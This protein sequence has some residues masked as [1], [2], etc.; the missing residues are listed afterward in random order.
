MYVCFFLFISEIQSHKN[1]TE[2]VFS[3]QEV[4]IDTPYSDRSICTSIVHIHTEE[5]MKSIIK[6]LNLNIT[7]DE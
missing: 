2:I 4:Q 5:R 1:S 7:L 6:I 3:F